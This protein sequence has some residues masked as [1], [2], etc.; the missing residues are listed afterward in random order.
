[1]SLQLLKTLLQNMCRFTLMKPISISSMPNQIKKF[2]LIVSTNFLITQANPLLPLR[3]RILRNRRQQ[4]KR[5]AMKIMIGYQSAYPET[6]FLLSNPIAE[7][8]YPRS[9]SPSKQQSETAFFVINWVKGL[10]I[11]AKLSTNMAIAVWGGN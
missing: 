8:Q 11:L 10:S 7:N 5:K 1:M 3:Q 6:M 9:Q 2:H 4:T